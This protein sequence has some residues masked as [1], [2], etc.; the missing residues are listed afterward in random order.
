MAHRDT[1]ANQA[2][3][4]PPQMATEDGPYYTAA[5]G[6]LVMSAADLTVEARWGRRR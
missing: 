2:Y 6:A 4:F 5:A 3:D 1:N